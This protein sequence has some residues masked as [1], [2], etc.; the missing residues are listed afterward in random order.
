MYLNKENPNKQNTQDENY[1]ERTHHA[2]LK[3]RLTYIVIETY[4]TGLRFL[5]AWVST[6]WLSTAVGE[7]KDGTAGPGEG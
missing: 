7:D 5:K 6:S 3:I 4:L 1:P 2:P